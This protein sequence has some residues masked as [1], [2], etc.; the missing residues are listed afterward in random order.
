MR[1]SFLYNLHSNGIRSG[2]VADPNK[3]K[4]VF[5]SRYGKVRI[6]E[7]IGVDMESKAWVADPKNRDCDVEGG[8]FCRG[9]YPPG[10]QGI[11][12]ER[13]DFAQLEDFNRNNK[14]EDYQKKYFENLNNPDKARRKAADADRKI[15]AER[16][17]E[18]PTIT[19]E[20][21]D[22]V[23]TSWRDTEQT[24]L[25]WKLIN[26]GATDELERWL[27]ADPLMA[28]IRSSDGRG[29][30]WWAFESRKQS[31]VKILMKAGLG[32]NDKDQYG[33]TPIDL[34][35]NDNQ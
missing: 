31:I 30:M 18:R 35:E 24:T 25:M 10:L 20:Q 21:I 9:Q 4:E 1:E 33:K 13:V 5:R 11:L 7:L 29:P 34:L 26:E 23:Y 32:H 14:D 17:E 15:E 6:Y 8:W 3:F 12:S 2:V 22:A 28:Y 27:E 19:Q 16:K